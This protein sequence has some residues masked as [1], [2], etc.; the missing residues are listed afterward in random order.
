MEELQNLLEKINREGIEKAD[1]EAAKII[2]EAQAKADELL[3]SAKA[4]AEKA[5]IDAENAAKA[6][7]QRAAETI[8]Q[9]A[10]DVV[11]GVKDSITAILEKLLGEDVR[12]ALANPQDT[13]KIVAEVV[14][15]FS[16]SGEICAPAEL[17]KALN[18]QLANLNSFTVASDDSIDAGFTIK[19]DNGRVEHDFT[20]ETIASELAKR[21]RP[22]LASL[23]K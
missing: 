2:S 13:A 8:R 9:A 17:V 10:R 4:E 22:D 18:T 3:A 19:L 21:L 6:Y 23:L 14:K 16:T 12:K 5:K 7:S 20:A 11:I 15:G 1:A